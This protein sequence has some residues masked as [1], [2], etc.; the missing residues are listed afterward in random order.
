[1]SVTVEQF[2]DYSCN[3]VIYEE[4]TE[5][6]KSIQDVTTVPI[7]VTVGLVPAGYYSEQQAVVIMD[8]QF[9]NLNHHLEKMWKR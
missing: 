9:L 8:P 3:F 2:R 7:D 4:M 5:V 6:V 1:M